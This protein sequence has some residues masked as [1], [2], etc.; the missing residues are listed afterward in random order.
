M[1]YLLKVYV[2]NKLSTRAFH[3]H[4]SDRRLL[5]TPYLAVNFSL[6]APR[7]CT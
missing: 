1:E 7:F 6:R 2:P 3:T 4:F 5:R